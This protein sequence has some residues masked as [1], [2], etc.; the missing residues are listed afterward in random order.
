MIYIFI[1]LGILIFF[2]FVPVFGKKRS[3]VRYT[4]REEKGPYTLPEKFMWGTSTAAQQIETQQKTDWTDFENSAYKN[5]RFDTLAPGKAKPGH[6]HNL[7]AYSK[8]VIKKKTDHDARIEKDLA[9]A[10]KLGH[11]AYRFSVDWARLFPKPGMSSPSKAG[12]AFYQ[13]V[14]DACRKNKLTPSLTLFHFSSPSWL[15]QDTVKG[16]ENPNTIEEFQSLTRGV[17]EHFIDQ[18]DHWCTLNEPMVYV[19]NGYLDGVFPPLEQRGNPAKVAPIISNLLKGHAAAYHIL[20]D[21]ARA[22]KKEIQVGLTQ[23][24]RAFEPYRNYAVLDRIT[25]SIIEQAFIWDMLDAIETGHFAPKTGG[26]RENIPGLAGTQDYVGINYY[27]RFYVKTDITRPMKFEVLMHDEHDPGEK[28][29]QLGW[30][31]YPKGFYDVLAS[32]HAKY[33]KPIYILENGT[34]DDQDDDKIRQSVLVNHLK[35]IYH[36]IK[37]KGADV[38]GYFHWSLID[39]FEWAEGFEARFG[40]VK[41]DYAKNFKRIPRPSAELY[42]EIIEANGVTEAIWRYYTALNEANG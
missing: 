29:N 21:A 36:V 20:H 35:E 14:L 19:Y 3:K 2:I 12:I 9:L 18:V 41:I 15:W 4:L 39:N 1:A 25:A 17:A 26:A 5:R 33:N 6:I 31:L 8:E 13:R 10:K 34:A 40:L 16:W 38:R 37:E 22:K 27:G 28:I 7:G 23:H 24:T 11:N 30:A 42:R 32:A